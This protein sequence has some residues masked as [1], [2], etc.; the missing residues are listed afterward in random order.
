[1]KWHIKLQS[2]QLLAEVIYTVI[3]IYFINEQ[4]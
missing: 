4:H 1:V 2:W 3:H